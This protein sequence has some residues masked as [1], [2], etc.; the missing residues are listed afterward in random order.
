MAGASIAR[1]LSIG[2]AASLLLTAAALA[3]V[4][5]VL[6]ERALREHAL[7]LLEDDARTV[8]AAVNSGP[9][10]LWIDRQHLPRMFERPL[11]GR[12]FVVVS[13]AGTWR[14]RSLWDHELEMP[15][16]AG[17]IPGLVAGPQGQRLLCLRT[18]YR[19]HGQTLA[20]MVAADVAPLLTDFRR[21][22]LLLLGLGAFSVLALTAMQRAWMRHS[23][24]EP[25]RRAGEQVHELTEGRRDRLDTTVAL[26]LQPLVAAINR[27]LAHT[28]QSLARSRQA[29]GNL[30]HALKTPLAVL[31]ALAERSDE[32]LR[33]KLLEQIAQMQQRITRE[34]GRARTAGALRGA[35]RFAPRQELPLL[36]RA[37][38]QAHARDIAITWEAPDATL[39]L[40][41][42]EE[43]LL[44]RE[45][46]EEDG[47]PTGNGP[48]IANT[49]LPEQSPET[50]AML[51]SGINRLSLLNGV[52]RAAL[53][54][55][56]LTVVA[57]RGEGR[58]VEAKKPD[59]LCEL[60]R[61]FKKAAG[62][63]AK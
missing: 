22:G 29:L 43:A 38:R 16:T 46:E 39:P 50:R 6:F 36:V 63:S 34:L 28:T 21:I 51:L 20:I 48:V 8:L 10:G 7:G 40:E 61:N 60:A 59:P 9:Q 49:E 2:L 25:L 26:E 52:R 45:I 24:L 58:I 17:A 14:S 47:R 56:E 27:L 35:L 12:Y 5:S 30:G 44:L 53:V 23:A 15:D 41:R 19:R 13:A 4:A 57:E 3:L 42:D 18:D 31:L 33:T 55:P 32:P 54:S 11:S 62:V 1:R 37:L